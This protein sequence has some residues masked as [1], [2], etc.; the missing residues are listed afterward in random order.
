MHSMPAGG[1]IAI[2]ICFFQGH[3]ASLGLVEETELV[4]CRGMRNCVNKDAH[5]FDRTDTHK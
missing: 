4:F 1:Y 3:N 5:I 2:F